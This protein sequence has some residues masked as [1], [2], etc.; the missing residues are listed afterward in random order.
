MQKQMWDNLKI[1]YQRAEIIPSPYPH[2]EEDFK[3]S[4]IIFL[5]SVVEDWLQK[6][7]NVYYY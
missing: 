6:L 5:G 3:K 4:Q 7:K 2:T 1:D